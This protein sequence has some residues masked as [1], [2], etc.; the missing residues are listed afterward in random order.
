MKHFVPNKR[1]GRK[2]SFKINKRAA[3][4]LGTSEYMNMFQTIFVFIQLTI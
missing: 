3:R 1:V 2:I 4:L